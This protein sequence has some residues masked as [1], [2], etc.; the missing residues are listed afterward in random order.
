MTRPSEGVVVVG[1]GPVGLTAATLLSNRGVPV[2]VLEAAPEPQTDWRASTFHA[3]TLELLTQAGV[4]EEMHAVGLP[5][6][7]Y[8]LRDRRLGV[9]AEFDFGLLRDE[10]QFPYRLQVNQQRLVVMLLER[11]AGRRGVSIRFDAEVVGVDVRGDGVDAFVRRAGG[12]ELVSGSFLIGADGAAST[13][14]KSLDIAF[15]GMTYPQQFLIVT[16]EEQLDELIPDLAHVA[17]VADPDEWL[18]LLRTPDSW[19]I[20]FPVPPGED[21]RRATSEQ[22][23]QRRLQGVA[24]QPQGYG[25]LDRQIYGV[26]QRVAET[27]SVGPALLAG[28]AAHI[29]SPLGGM[30]LNSGIHDAVDAAIR[31]AR[32]W[33]GDAADP[34]AELESYAERRRTVALEYVRAD[35]HRNTVMLQER[36]DAVRERNRQEMRQIAADPQ[37]A[38]EW[39]LRASMLA[40]VRAQGIGVRPG[41]AV[42]VRR[43]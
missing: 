10:T 15:E 30:G 32:I 37:R 21:P 29:N 18:F 16:I 5:V 19:R 41:D 20:V 6:A 26:H 2:T 7:R 4:V 39:L 3:A 24:P 40:P 23:L 43:R 35:T 13:V 8:Q 38:R 34:A 25:I 12:S 33:Y 36:D 28:D 42:G 1:A 17:Y 9:V 31:I 14:R 22:T 27:F 11:L